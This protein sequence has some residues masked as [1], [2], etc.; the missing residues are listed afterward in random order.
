MHILLARVEL[1]VWLVLFLAISVIVEG[2][3]R[4]IRQFRKR[5]DPRRYEDITWY[6]PASTKPSELK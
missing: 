1:P 3:L 2:V 5:P 6:K 4:L